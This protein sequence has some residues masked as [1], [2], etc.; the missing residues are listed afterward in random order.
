MSH[1]LSTEERIKIETLLDLGTSKAKIALY[2]GRH[3][4]TIYRELNRPGICDKQYN[5]ELYHK[6][7]RQ[8][9]GRRLEIAPSE[10]I[11]LLVNLPG[12]T[13]MVSSRL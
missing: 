2:L 3:R 11:I 1:H 8:N 12:L 10:E 6:Q 7:A 9:M 4:S 13:P 5:A